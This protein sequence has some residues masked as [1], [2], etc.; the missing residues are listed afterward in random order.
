[1]VELFFWE[2]DLM[3]KLIIHNSY[4]RSPKTY[5]PLR[6]VESDSLDP[7]Q[8]IFLEYGLARLILTHG[9]GPIRGL[10]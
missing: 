2:K 3:L 10:I 1:M 7:V 5:S 8:L 6:I 9:Y 4:C